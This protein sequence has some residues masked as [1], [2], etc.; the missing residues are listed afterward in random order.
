MGN[1][2][3][4]VILC[5]LLV[6]RSVI[7][8]GGTTIIPPTLAC[9]TNIPPKCPLPEPCPAVAYHSSTVVDDIFATNCYCDKLCALYRDCCPHIYSNIL[10]LPLSLIRDMY[11][12]LYKGSLY[13]YM[14]NKCPRN[15]PNDW[16]RVNCEKETSS[17]IF[18]DWPVSDEE[19]IAYNNVYCSLCH[20]KSNVSYWISEITCRSRSRNGASHVNMSDLIAN[21]SLSKCERS[22]HPPAPNRPGRTCK[23]VT[24]NCPPEW[25]DTCVKELCEQSFSVRYVYDHHSAY[26]NEFCARCN[27]VPEDIISCEQVPPLSE[28]FSMPYPLS[29]IFDLNDGTSRSIPGKIGMT[30]D[31]VSVIEEQLQSCAWNEVFDPFSQRCRLVTCKPD[32][33]LQD[34]QCLRQ[35]QA[36]NSSSTNKSIDCLRR[37]LYPGEYLLQ[38]DGHLLEVSTGDRYEPD[39]F[40]IENN[41]ALVCTA[42]DRNYTLNVTVEMSVLVFKFSQAQSIVSLVGHVISI[43]CLVIMICVYSLLEQLRNL[44]GRSIMCL[45]ASLLCAQVLFLSCLQQTG[46]YSLCVFFAV[47]INFAFLAAFFWMNVM[48]FDIWSTFASTRTISYT[49]HT[50]RFCQYSLYAWSTPLGIVL[51]SLGVNFSTTDSQYSPGY[52]E[53]MCWFTRRLSMTIFF[54]LPIIIIIFIN[55]VFYVLTVL[56]IYRISTETKHIKISNSSEK[57]TDL[58]LYMK[59][60]VIMGLTWIF[61]FVATL[62]EVEAIW[63]LFII[64]NSLQ[65]A[66]ICVGFVF[67]KKVLKLLRN[68]FRNIIGARP[69]QEEPTTKST[70]L[71]KK[72]SLYA[73]STSNQMSTHNRHSRI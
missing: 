50:K 65:G 69:R 14:I 63:Y 66:F 57:K 64:F 61:G 13:F 70:E 19:G 42:W 43:I 6:N 29:V 1:S 22:F 54:G 7:M 51:V 10:D 9:K 15:W 8:A 46:V 71:S 16:V 23:E 72:M 2:V 40:F 59:L 45:G 11:A 36:N 25:N 73:D 33:T 26:K 55:G 60:S 68:K 37:K 39:Y 4:Y 28:V 52:G 27:S 41:T 35:D 31:H 20:G 38:S 56:N 12:C 18:L 3:V 49:K 17:D 47:V 34:G 5:V 32:F 48:S 24:S 21:Q 62:S 53:G 30:E 67:T 58:F 44:P